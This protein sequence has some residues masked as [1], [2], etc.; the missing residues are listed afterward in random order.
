MAF[1]EE[2]GGMGVVEV[3]GRGLGIG[4]LGDD[5]EADVAL[6]R[7]LLRPTFTHTPSPMPTRRCPSTNSHARDNAAQMRRSPCDRDGRI[8]A[9]VSRLP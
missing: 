6:R 3:T 9:P 2:R 1:G 4:A 5:G 7:L 8:K